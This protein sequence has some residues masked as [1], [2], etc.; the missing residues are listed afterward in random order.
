MSQL[1]YKVRTIE[2]IKFDKDWVTYVKTS[3]INKELGEMDEGEDV[4]YEGNNE[5]NF[6]YIK[7]YNM[8]KSRMKWLIKLIL[9]IC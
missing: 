2:Q 7:F 3:I 4:I 9:M 6:M 1:G 8:V 5:D